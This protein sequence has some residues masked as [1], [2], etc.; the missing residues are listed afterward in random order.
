MSILNVTPGQ[1]LY[2]SQIKS[3]LGGSW[4][5]PFKFF[6]PNTPYKLRFL[7]RTIKSADFNLNASMNPLD[8]RKKKMKE[9]PQ[10][11]YNKKMGGLFT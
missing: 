6:Y 2:L 7:T 11:Q 1:S 5:P 4:Y 8:Q 10:L 3:K 9:G